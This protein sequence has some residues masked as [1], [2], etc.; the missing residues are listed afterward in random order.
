MSELRDLTAA[1]R[2]FDKR[3]VGVEECLVVLVRNSEQEADWRHEQRNL[4]QRH[5]LEGEERDR[6]LKQVQEACGAISHKMVELVE[7]LDNYAATRQADVRRIHELE[8]ARD[9]TADEI[10]RP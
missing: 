5:Q 3:I 9:R 7:R 2:A 10:T 8:R 1:L 4:A 6:A